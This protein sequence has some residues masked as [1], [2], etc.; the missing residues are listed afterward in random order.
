MKVLRNSTTWGVAAL[1]VLTVL[2]VVAAMVYVSPPGHR[3]IT[4]YTDDAASIR[5]GDDVRIAGISVGTVKDLTLEQERVRVRAQVD[6]SAFVGD[7][8]QI[9]VR[10]L[11]VVGGYYVN[12]VSLGAKPLGT[13]PIPSERVLM[14]YSLIRTLSDATKITDNLAAKPINQSLNEIQQGLNGNN[15]QSLTAVIDSGNTL[16][17][18]IDRQR[19]QVTAILDMSQ[20]YIRSLNVNREM[21]TQM[22]QKMAI[23]E[24]T[25]VLYSK[26]FAAALMG[27]GEIV[28]SIGPV[29]TFYLNHR[30]DV[31]EKLRQWQQR[32]RM[33]IDRNGVIVRVLTRTRDHI[34]RVLDAQNAAPQLLATDL[35]IPV[36]GSPC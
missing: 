10:M 7:K 32:A 33:W 15:L 23:A 25:L 9:Q 36:P 14:P 5:P 34:E 3:M 11:T 18:M 26:G 19:G 13:E 2:A 35:C 20:E 6:D 22:V 16:M 29:G 8:S 4:F 1:A 31:L 30:D 27:L 24:Q 21:L 28:S 17:S 12:L